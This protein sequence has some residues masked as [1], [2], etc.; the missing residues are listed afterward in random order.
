LLAAEMATEV[1]VDA[2]TPWQAQ[3]S[4][5]RIRPERAAKTQ[6]KWQAKLRAAAQ[7]SRRAFIPGL[8]PVV[9]GSAIAQLHAP[10]EGQHLVVLHED[11]QD[12]LD[13]IVDALPE[14]TSCVH[15]AV[16]PEGG[17]TDEEI[18]AVEKAGG[19]VLKLG[20]QV[21]RASTVG[22]IVIEFLYLLLNRL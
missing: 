2:V 15:L 16:G 3:R 4:I 14:A 12:D 20:T 11:G 6:A 13:G 22:P 8:H 5:V 9:Q 19:S 10:Q 17:I 18:A 7:Q 1:G 21:I